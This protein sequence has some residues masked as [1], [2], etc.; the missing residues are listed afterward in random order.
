MFVLCQS[1]ELDRFQAR[2]LSGL[3]SARRGPDH[4]MITVQLTPARPLSILPPIRTAMKDLLKAQ[5]ERVPEEPESEDDRIHL[6]DIVGPTTVS[7]VGGRADAVD[8]EELA[9]ELHDEM[10]A[11]EKLLSS[12]RSGGG[13]GQA[14]AAAVPTRRYGD[15]DA[16]PQEVIADDSAKQLD[17]IKSD[18]TPSTIE[19]K[20]ATARDRDPLPAVPVA[21][22]EERSGNRFLLVVAVAGIAGLGVMAFLRLVD[23]G[24]QAPATGRGIQSQSVPANQGTPPGKQPGPPPAV[25]DPKAPPPAKQA[26]PPGKAPPAPPQG[27]APGT[28]R[29]SE[30]NKPKPS[31]VPPPP[32]GS[33]AVEAA[34]AS[35]KVRVVDSLLMTPGKPD[36]MTWNA[37]SS[38]C[39]GRK[40]AGL[41]GW[42]LPSR[43]Q[44]KKLRRAR[45]LTGA[46]YW[47]RT[48]AE[49]GD[50]AYAYD[51]KSAKVHVYLTVEPIG[52]PVCVKKR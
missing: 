23:D 39:R 45:L 48:R 32:K 18:L 2:R 6:R 3:F 13:G 41:K 12:G 22:P 20:P 31:T 5:Y 8:P 33:A 46:T 28:K 43:A 17:V 11:A 21:A 34:I 15:A 40:T 50:E 47:S 52:R 26:T 10:V 25:A 27:K 1:D 16:A 37:A 19:A 29:P 49:G 24:G 38:H 14:A 4:K 44:L 42:Q 35:G 7:A 30:P 51:A 36:T 9:R